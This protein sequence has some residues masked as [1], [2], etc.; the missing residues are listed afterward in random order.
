MKNFVWYQDKD[1]NSTFYFPLGPKNW[2][3]VKFANRTNN[4]RF[5]KLNFSLSDDLVNPVDEA[6]NKMLTQITLE[7]KKYIIKR[8][9]E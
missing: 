3:L 1:D 4:F 7:N 8:I 9:F 6:Q 2:Y 5:D